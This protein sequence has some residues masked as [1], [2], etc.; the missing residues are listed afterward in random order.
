MQESPQ[1]ALESRINELTEH[2]SV[3]RRN[4]EKII[5]DNHRMREV[6]RIAESELRKRRDQVQKL[7]NE[8][9][10][11]QNNRLEAKARVEHAMEK[12]DDLISSGQQGEAS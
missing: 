11:L 4:M 12:L 3:I 6:V 9:K 7:E 5:A 1:Q 8:L 2:L 10:G